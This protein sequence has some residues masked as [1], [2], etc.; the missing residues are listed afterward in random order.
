MD[1]VVDVY[2]RCECCELR[3]GRARARAQGEASRETRRPGM[4]QPRY[5]RAQHMPC[6][7][8]LHKWHTDLHWRH[9]VDEWK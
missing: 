4:Q 3:R 1:P 7:D 8:K 5:V 6:H 9:E 2:F